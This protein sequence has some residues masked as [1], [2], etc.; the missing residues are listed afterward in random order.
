MFLTTTSDMDTFLQLVTVLILF[1]IVL[2]I[3]YFTT[4]WIANYEKGKLRN[5]NIEVI[6]TY[7]VMTNKYIQ[8]VR[9][10]DKYLV[11][12]LGK[13]D[14]SML[15]ELEKD[16]ILLEDTEVSNKSFKEILEKAKNIKKK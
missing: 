5:R 16:Q 10:G 15:A 8:I 2:T 1:V 9:T 6:E 11:I 3:T 14:I 13:D 7:K 4:R 12:A